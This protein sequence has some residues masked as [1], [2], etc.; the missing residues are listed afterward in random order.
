M[1]SKI[2]RNRKF[3]VNVEVADTQCLSETNVAKESDLWLKR[4]G[5]LNFKSLG[6]LN[7][8]NQVLGILKIVA[9][10]KSRDV[11]MKGKYLRFPFSSEL[12]S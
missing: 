7:S 11:C 5:Y 4:L 9:P 10:E 1:P 8:N 6:Y 12:T 2:G 3:K